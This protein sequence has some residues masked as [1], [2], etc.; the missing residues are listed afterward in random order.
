MWRRGSFGKKTAKKSSNSSSNR[1]VKAVSDLK[2]PMF[3][4]NEDDDTDVH[5]FKR[6]VKGARP[7]PQQMNVESFIHPNFFEELAKRVSK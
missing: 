6:V 1:S 5:G 4:V 7:M 3:A 2:L